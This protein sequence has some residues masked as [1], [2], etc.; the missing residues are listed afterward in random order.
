MTVIAP[1]NIATTAAAMSSAPFMSVLWIVVGE[2]I[3][4]ELSVIWRVEVNVADVCEG[5]M[6]VV[7]A[8]GTVA[9]VGVVVEVGAAY[10]VTLTLN[11][12]EV[13]ATT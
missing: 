13:E 10:G 4:V 2:N 5:M 11:C 6:F 9:V 3:D 7:T 8:V 12:S 1:V